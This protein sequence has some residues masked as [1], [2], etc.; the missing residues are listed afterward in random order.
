MFP[1]YRYFHCCSALMGLQPKAGGQIL[2][3]KSRPAFMTTE[4]ILLTATDLHTS[5]GSFI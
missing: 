2:P 5:F 3:M 1:D 4:N